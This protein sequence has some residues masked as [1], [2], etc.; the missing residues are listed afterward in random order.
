MKATRSSSPADVLHRDSDLP[1]LRRAV[2]RSRSGS[3]WPRRRR[4]LRV[5]SH[6]VSAT[7]SRHRSSSTTSLIFTTRPASPC[8]SSVARR[9]SSSRPSAASTSSRTARI[10]RCDSRARVFRH[11]RPSTPTTPSSTSARS[12]S[13]WRRGYASAGRS[14]RT[15][16]I[17]R[18]I[19][20]KSDGGSCPLTQRIIAE[21]LGGGR[22]PSHIDRVQTTYRT[23]PRCDGR[24]ASARAA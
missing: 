16:M 18:M 2:H 10:A 22:L 5:S 23:E 12:R 11:S 19:Q 1:Q 9:S 7:D 15:D 14:H 20:L 13:S 24:R 4:A 8:R 17:A 3:R 21:F 6:S